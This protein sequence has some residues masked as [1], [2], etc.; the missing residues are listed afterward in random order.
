MQ[1]IQASEDRFTRF[2]EESELSELNRSAGTPFKASAD[3]F[4]V[5]SLAQKFFHQTR[6]L[7]D[8]SILPDLKRI[9]YDRSMDLLRQTGSKPMLETILDG[10]HPSFS[11][12]ELDDARNMI[13]LPTGMSIDLGGLAKGWI[14]EQAA[15]ILADYSE[16]CAVD[17]GGDMFLVG[18]P[19]GEEQWSV[20]LEDPLQPEL[21]LTTL[22]VDPGAIAT[23]SVAKRTWKQG[24]KLRHHLIDPRTRE[25]AITDWL[26]MTVIAPHSYEAEVYAKALLI[27]GAKECED[28]A[29]A[30]GIQLF[31]LAVDPTGKLWGTQKS[32]EFVYAQ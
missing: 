9:G 28:I 16:A 17:A 25:P 22:K 23:S 4:T 31:Y 1:F 8:P 12:M 24:E 29:R 5:V 32:L 10:E 3:L 19:K 26:S 11:E 7:F 30:S 14:A 2:H 6:G 27:G 21:T 18:L 15:L 20:A 13:L